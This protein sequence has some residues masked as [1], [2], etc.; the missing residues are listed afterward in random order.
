MKTTRQKKRKTFNINGITDRN[1]PG[2]LVSSRSLDGKFRFDTKY[3]RL[4]LEE[5]R[6]AAAAD[7]V[8]VGAVVVHRGRVIA[9]GRNRIRERCDP[10][11]HAEIL[12]LRSAGTHLK[13]ERLT[14]ATL[15]TT[16]EP[17]P[18][19]AG[20]LVLARVKR[21]VYAA[22]DP[23]AGAGGSLMDLLRHPKLNHQILV[24]GQVLS[25]LSRQRLVR[26]FKLKRK[27]A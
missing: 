26:F 16:L 2:V 15:Y 13:R 17:C 10:T 19:C 27:K 12:A 23:K 6:L 7:E 20:A 9:K 22:S 8:P 14:E 11:A 21:V 18:M 25:G 24:T 5:A 3:M 1:N 4:A